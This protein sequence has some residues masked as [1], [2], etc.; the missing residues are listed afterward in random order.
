LT[1]SVALA[2]GMM[3]WLHD[4][5]SGGPGQ[6]LV[7]GHGWRGLEGDGSDVHSFEYGEHPS[8][9]KLRTR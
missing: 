1:S 5:R 3:V 2:A 9:L 6:S 4:R 7:A 8:W